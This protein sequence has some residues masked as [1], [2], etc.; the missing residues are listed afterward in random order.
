MTARADVVLDALG[1]GVRRQIITMLRM[2]PMTV[3][4]IAEALPVSRPAVSKH[5]RILKGADLVASESAGTRNIFHL[6]KDGFDE[7]RDWIEGFWDEALMR[8]AM[9]AENTAPE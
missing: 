3:G 4:A 2:R 9:V 5:L 6:K 7:A 8:F 1:N